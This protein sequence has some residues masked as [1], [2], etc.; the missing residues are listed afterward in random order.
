MPDFRELS[1]LDA[2][3]QAELCRRGQVSAE[4]LWDACQARLAAL[5]PLLRTVVAPNPERA[6]PAPGPL[7]GV[8]FLVK[9]SQPWPG[10]RWTLG[11]RLFR[12]RV[13]GQHTDYGKRLVESGLVCAGKTALSEFGLLAST[14]SLLFGA[15]HNPWQ[16]SRSAF[17][18]SG[19][20]AVAV[21]AGLVPLAH[22]NDGGGSIRVPASACGVFGFKPS[23]GRTVNANRSSSDF[24]DMTSEHCVS[25]SVRDSA[26]FLSLTE[27]TTRSDVV[28]FVNE[29]GRQR[30]KIGAFTQTMGGAEPE[31]SV[32]AA[33]QSAMQLL[34]ELGHHVEPIPAPRYQVAELGE[35]FYLV[36]A[37]AIRNVVDTID[38]TRAEPVQQDELEPF[39]WALLDLLRERGDDLLRGGDVLASARATFADAVWTYRDAT[40]RFD[41]VLTPTVPVEPLPLG[42]LSPVLPL[43]IV[44]ERSLRVLGYTPIHNIAGSPAMSVPLHWSATG[45]PIGAQ[46]ASAPGQDAR[47]L[48][49]AHELERARPWHARWPLYSIP[50]SAEYDARA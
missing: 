14:E 21:A 44:K 30:L 3:A 17:G 22:A 42:E 47:L 2:I 23:R 45:L 24:T 41:A 38:R 4:E 18:S 40:A 9:D 48:G 43:A 33:H 6:K 50:A 11:A 34:T 32:L 46:L 28:G 16:L 19:G 5:E 25:R 49:L 27:D 31:P 12:E 36:A 39:T 29:P 8:P 1:R 13:T 15:T 20:S 7:A 37:A 35:A 10:L 26:L